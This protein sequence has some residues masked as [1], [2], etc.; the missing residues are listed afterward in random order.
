VPITPTWTTNAGT[1]NS[2]GLLTAQTTVASGRLVTATYNAVNGTATVTITPD[3]PFTLTLQAGPASLTVGNS[4][5]LTATLTDRFGNFVTNGTSVSFASSIGNVLTPRT[6]TNGVAT[7]SI[8]STLAGTAIVTASFSGAVQDTVNVVFNPGAFTRLS[9]ESGPP[10]TGSPVGTVTMSL[11]DTLTVYAVG[12]DVYNNLIGSQTVS[13]FGTGVLAGRL[14]PAAGTSTTLTPAP[15]VSG[16]GFIT[17]TSGGITDTTGLITILAPNLVLTKEDNQDPVPAGQSLGYTIVVTNVG[18]TAAQNVVITE[19]YDPNVTFVGASPSP[20][21][22]SGGTRWTFSTLAPGA[23]QE[24]Q[25]FTVVAGSM[26][27]GAVLTN[28]VRASAA[29]LAQSVYTVTTQVDVTP[30]LVIAKVQVSPVGSTVRVSDTI[31]YQIVY[32]NTGT[33]IL[34]NVVVTE[35]YHSAVEFVNAVPAPTSGDN[36]WSVGTLQAGQSGSIVVSVRVTAPQTDG[37]PLINTVT[38]DSNETTPTTFQLP[39]V[40]IRAPMLSL[41]KHASGSTVQADAPLTYTLRYTNSGSTNATSVVITDLL[42]S[43][44]TFQ[45]ATPAPSQQ[46]GDLLTWTFTEVMTDSNGLITVR[47]RTD[48]NQVNGTVFTNTARIRAAELVSAFA[49]IANTIASAPDVRLTQ[50]DGVSSA[51]AGQVLTYTLN[52]TNSGNAPANNVVITDRI[53]SNVS[54]QNCSPSCTSGSGVYTFT[55]G[56]LNA[57]ST[58]SARITVRVDSTLPAGLRAITNTARIRTSTS[59]DNQA[60]NFGEDA[61][62]ISTVPVLDIRAVYSTTTPYPTKMVTY[63]VRYTNTSAMATTGVVISTTQSPYVTYVSAGS[64]AW[65]NVGGNAFTYA[66]GN[67]PAGASGVLTFVVTLPTTFTEE[68]DGFTNVFHVRDDGPGGLPVATDIHNA[69]LG[70]PDL[71]IESVSISPQAVSAGMP[72]TATV[73]VRNEGTGR[74]CNPDSTPCGA[75]NLNVFIDPPAAPPSY[76]FSTTLQYGYL[77]GERFIAF[78]D[79]GQ[80]VTLTITNLSFTAT[81]SFILYFKVDNWNCAVGTPCIPDNAQHSLVPE[82][83]EYNNVFGPLPV[84]GPPNRLFLPLVAKNH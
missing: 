75:F 40:G 32:T 11:Y 52:Y 2:A 3:V 56:T 78:L 41:S 14:A 17:A 45:S 76:G 48:N 71:I 66:V 55:L 1:I 10:G 39:P 8:S 83:D 30:T 34:N 13:W 24:I 37:T 35:T 20:V 4:S 22:G 15:I 62:T 29:R 50:S 84:P 77:P 9:L 57:A 44:V 28:T 23:R 31:N 68:M 60:N 27:V 36:R 46:S 33:A 5:A 19:T 26:P 49:S 73:V 80:A 54:F 70:V 38:I 16:T 74:A 64:S 81:Q 18:T 51:A 72:F 43:N 67:L 6:T 58:G 61:D 82:S 42:P 47:V 63:T 69:P 65:V 59:G 53:P 25:V 79:A 21:P 7:S 12:Y